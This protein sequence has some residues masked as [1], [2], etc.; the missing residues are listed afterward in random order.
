MK[1]GKSFFLTTKEESEWNVWPAENKKKNTFFIWFYVTIVIQV[2][3][4]LSVYIFF[5]GKIWILNF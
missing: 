4:Y 1:V 2:L 5:L 3:I